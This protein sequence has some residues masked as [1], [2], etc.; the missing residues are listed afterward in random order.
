SGGPTFC[1]I[2]SL[3]L[4]PSSSAKLTTEEQRQSIR[5][6]VQNQDHA[7]GFHGRTEKESDACYC[8]WCGA[9]LHLL[10]QQSLVDTTALS[11][12]VNHCQFK[13]GGVAKAPG[14]TP[15]MSLYP[16]GPES[17]KSWQLKTL[18]PLLNA[19]QETADWAV[20]NIPARK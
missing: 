9:A 11:S 17:D 2:A 1:A 18:D 6:L 16:P 15:A 4:A 14:E 19:T 7:G 12:F 5:W 20:Q 13:F 10:G 8:F 3:R